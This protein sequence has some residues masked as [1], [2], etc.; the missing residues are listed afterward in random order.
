MFTVTC[1]RPPANAEV[2]A[3]LRV[4]API[5]L[6]DNWKFICTDPIPWNAAM[7]KSSIG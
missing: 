1:G 6:D 2:V 7:G 4:R 5:W 3:I